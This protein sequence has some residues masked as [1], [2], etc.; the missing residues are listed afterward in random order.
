MAG[1]A[2]LRLEMISYESPALRKKEKYCMICLK[3][4]GAEM[5]IDEL[6]AEM[7]SFTLSLIHI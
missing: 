3:H 1:K 7:R 6:G 5:H 2:M 4:N